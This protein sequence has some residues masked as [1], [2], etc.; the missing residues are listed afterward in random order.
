MSEFYIVKIFSSLDIKN[1]AAP[2]TIRIRENLAQQGVFMFKLFLPRSFYTW[3]ENVYVWNFRRAK[4]FTIRRHLAKLLSVAYHNDKD[5]NR[6][7]HANSNDR[8]LMQYS[9][10]NVHQ[11]EA[12]V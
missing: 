8:Q 6:P 1:P 5:K 12:D 11:I 10:D 4:N 3:I 7:L 9:S 2:K